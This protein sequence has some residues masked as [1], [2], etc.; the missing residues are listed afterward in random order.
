MVALLYL[1]T[2]GPLQT[3][4]PKP[5]TSLLTEVITI[6]CL[7]VIFFTICTVSCIDT[8]VKPIMIN[9]QHALTHPLLAVH[10]WAIPAI[11]LSAAKSLADLAPK[12]IFFVFALTAE[13]NFNRIICAQISDFNTRK[14]KTAS[15]NVPGGSS[16]SM[17]KQVEANRPTEF[18]MTSTDF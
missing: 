14:A 16:D 4:R 15:K 5:L 18:F 3:G 9:A 17:S 7:C 1:S 12:C 8:M 13:V 6:F 2:K 10:A 11:L